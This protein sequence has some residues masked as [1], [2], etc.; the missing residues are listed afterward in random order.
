[1]VFAINITVAH[2]SQHLLT[3]S[4]GYYGWWNLLP[5]EVLFACRDAREDTIFENNF[6][7]G[8]NR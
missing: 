1:M 6:K 8:C 3:L 7:K 5:A 4:Y 2:F